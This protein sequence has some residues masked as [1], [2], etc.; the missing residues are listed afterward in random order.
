MENVHGAIG[1][2]LSQGRTAWKR[3]CRQYLTTLQHS[4]QKQERVS[5]HV[6]ILVVLRPV[7]FSSSTSGS[8]EK[9]TLSKT[10][11]MPNGGP[12]TAQP[13]V[14]VLSA[15]GSAAKPLK[16]CSLVQSF[17]CSLGF[18]FF[19]FSLSSLL[20]LPLLIAQ[21][22]LSLC[23]SLPLSLSVSLSLSPSP[24]PSLSLPPSICLSFSLSV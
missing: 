2:A 10:E 11:L 22:N 23:M 1:V 12:A 9:H 7:S 17:S 19:S 24:S 13:C 5:R 3:W 14:D 21:P 4:A 18:S 15:K 20:L 6:F 16:A 8:R